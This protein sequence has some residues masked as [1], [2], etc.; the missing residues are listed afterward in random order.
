MN[1]KISTYENERKFECDLHFA[2][3]TKGRELA[4]V[5]FI[6]RFTAVKAI[7]GSII[8]GK[9]LN[10]VTPDHT[11]RVTPLS[12]KILHRSVGD[13]C[14][15]LLLPESWLTLSRTPVILAPDGDIK[16][17]VGRYLCKHFPVPVYFEK[18][19][20]SLLRWNYAKVIF[21]PEIPQWKNLKAV[22]IHRLREG[23]D[24]TEE[25]LLQAIAKELQSKK[26]Q[27]PESDVEGKFDP[28]WSMNEYLKANAE[29]FSKQINMIKP[30][31]DPSKDTIH[32]AVVLERI[33]FPRQAHAAM[34]LVKTLKKERLAI[35]AGAMGTGKTLTALSVCNVLHS[36]SSKKDTRILITAPGITI[37]KWEKQEI[38]ESLPHAQVNVLTSTE[39]AARYLRLARTGELPSGLCFTLVGIDRAKL[40]PEPWCAA[41][42]KRISGSKE[43]AWHCPDCGKWLPDPD[44]EKKKEEVPAGWQMFAGEPFGEGKYRLTGRSATRIKWRTPPKMRKC[45]HCGASLWRP[46]LKNR[47]ETANK[48]RWYI[49]KILKKL[50]KHFDLYICDE[51]HQVKAQD[52]GR[53]SAFADM[54]KSS[55][56]VL[57]LTGTL[58]NGMSTSI[59]ELLWRVDPRSLLD[60]GF[61]H[62]TGAIQWASRYGVLERVIKTSGDDEGIVTHRKKANRQPQEKPGIAPE[63][64]ASHL[65]HR[66]VFLELSD[67]G[68]PLVEFNEIPVFVTLDKEHE[69]EYRMFHSEL[70]HIC[71][72]AYATGNINAFSKFNPAT[73]CAVDRSDMTNVV[74]VYGYEVLFPGFGADY[75]NAKERKLVEI[76]TESLAEGKG[77]VIYVYYS[78]RYNVHKRLQQVLKRHGIAAE[79]LESHISPEARFEW[80]HEAEKRGVKVIICNMRLVEV[81]LDLLPWQNIIFYQMSYD[82]N[83]V[84]QAAYR[85]W[86]IGQFRACKTY[87]LV[88]NGTQQMAQ[89]KSCML[90]RAQALLAE[91]RIDRSELKEF[92]RDS[93]TCLAADLAEC[94]A[95]DD[96]SDKWSRLAK[97][98]LGTE[99]T[100]ES[101]FQEVL[102]QA[103]KELTRETL[104]LAGLLK[105]SSTGK[106][107]PKE[108]QVV[109]LAKPPQRKGRK[110]AEGQLAFNFV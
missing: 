24:L 77:V 6:G 89:F 108:A 30:L 17:A 20:L 65:L 104:R 82:I 45:P 88:A 46:A 68:L 96:I 92:G 52:S 70:R 72:Q 57:A 9:S 31:H 18:E 67:L 56:K 35:L 55:K 93:H 83:T 10:I 101:K 33:P 2:V 42:W 64:I 73:I 47:G 54:V 49:S 69:K 40:G 80:L 107:A 14:H 63:L 95:G 81:G 102:S 32:P 51:V 23:H 106:E 58:V 38:A 110:V 62:K 90:K 78:D 37:P 100:S 39:D 98:D 22:Q 16:T 36:D 87:Y 1:Y 19:Y 12:M 34:G 21:N 103:Q 109:M 43:Y 8:A 84:R 28:S 7:T 3:L 71:S 91:G 44:L 75:E 99:T 5:S 13:A 79:I 59:K 41:L 11:M 66:S 86:R 74:D 50:G 15:A 61:N 26:L 27:I 4:T 76:V 85:A 25:N 105:D 97:I 60:L 48:P 94:L 29:I 53:G